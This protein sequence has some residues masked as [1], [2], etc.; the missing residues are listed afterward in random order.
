MSMKTIM[1]GIDTVVMASRNVPV[2]L[3]SWDVKTVSVHSIIH[4]FLPSFAPFLLRSFASFLLR[5]FIFIVCFVTF[6]VH[7]ENVRITDI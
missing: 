1:S 4:Y 2:D 7:T 6:L 3:T 5:F